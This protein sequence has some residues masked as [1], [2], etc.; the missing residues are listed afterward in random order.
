MVPI[1]ACTVTNILATHLNRLSQT[2]SWL[3][4]GSHVRDREE[5]LPTVACNS[6]LKAVIYNTLSFLLMG[7]L[8]F[9]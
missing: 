1:T 9:S 4:K 2:R 5:C 7:L 3:R 6:N 8:S